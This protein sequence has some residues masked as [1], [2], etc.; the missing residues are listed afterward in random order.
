MRKTTKH[1]QKFNPLQALSLLF[2]LLLVIYAFWAWI[3]SLSYFFSLWPLFITWFLSHILYL[4][5]FIYIDCPLDTKSDFCVLN[6]LR[7]N[8]SLYTLF[9]S[10]HDILLEK[11]KKKESVRWIAF[12]LPF[13]L[14]RIVFVSVNDGLWHA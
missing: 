13:C 1:M 3:I 4:V 11:G 12:I 14:L 2:C 10:N 5:F 8:F 9:L 6:D 7:L